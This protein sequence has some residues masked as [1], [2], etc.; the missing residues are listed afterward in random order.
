[1]ETPL[2]ILEELRRP[3][4]RPLIPVCPRPAGVWWT[5]RSAVT[6][7]GHGSNSPAASRSTSRRRGMGSGGIYFL[8][9]QRVADIPTVNT[10]PPPSLPSSLPPCLFLS[11]RSHLHAFTLSLLFF[12]PPSIHSWAW[13]GENRAR[14]K[15]G[16]KKKKKRT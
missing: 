16:R 12:S 7:L 3:V 4:Q 1:M 9:T 14:L 2:V 6:S 15:E 13:R 10:H 5:G 11:V 8:M